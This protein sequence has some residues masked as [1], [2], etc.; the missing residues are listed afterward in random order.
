MI[1]SNIFLADSRVLL[2]HARQKAV[3]FE[4]DNGIEIPIDYLAKKMADHAQF[5]TQHAYGRAFGCW[6]DFK[7][8]YIS[9]TIS[10]V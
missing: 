5:F 2:E 3:E 8:V 9:C 1:S 10:L 6:F 7:Q 4:F